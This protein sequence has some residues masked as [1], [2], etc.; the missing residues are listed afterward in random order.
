MFKFWFLNFSSLE[1]SDYE[2][3]AQNA[4]FDSSNTVTC[5]NITILQDNVIEE[6][7][8]VQLVLASDNPDIIFPVNASIT[9][10]DTSSKF[11]MG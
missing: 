1:N 7:E 11:L 8:T 9:I 3:S 5:L 6:Q 10:N 4:T 2:L